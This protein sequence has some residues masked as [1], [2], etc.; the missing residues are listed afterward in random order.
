MADS[1]AALF[2]AGRLEYVAA[3][4]PANVYGF[5]AGLPLPVLP[6][7]GHDAVGWAHEAYL[8]YQEVLGQ[9]RA[10]RAAAALPTRGLIRLRLP[11]IACFVDSNRARLLGVH[12]VGLRDGDGYY[13]RQLRRQLREVKTWYRE[14]RTFPVCVD[15]TTR[16]RAR[17]SASAPRSP[18]PAPSH[19]GS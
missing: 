3:V 9:H 16:R 10:A 15:V 6:H 18:R 14:R 17:T 4:V 19:R 2:V 8:R 12:D 1:G 11:R 5:L 7:D 13:D